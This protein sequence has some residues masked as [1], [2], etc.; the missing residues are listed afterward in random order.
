MLVQ[1]FEID[2]PAVR[3]AR[4]GHRISLSG[5]YRKNV[6]VVRQ[7]DIESARGHQLFR[8]LQIPRVYPLVIHAH[9]IDRRGAEAKRWPH[10]AGTR[11]QA[12]VLAR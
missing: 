6:G 2:L 7:Q 11:F 1:Q 4:D 5:R 3:V 9:D 8:S 10:A 12:G